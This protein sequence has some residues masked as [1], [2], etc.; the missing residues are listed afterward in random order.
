MMVIEFSFDLR[1][2][3][4]TRRQLLELTAETD[5]SSAISG[6][7]ASVSGF[8]GGTEN[9]LFRSGRIGSPRKSNHWPRFRGITTHSAPPPHAT[10]RTLLET[11]D[12]LP[13]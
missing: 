13:D 6:E 10:S 4:A 1:G 12:A 3:A 2:L 9:D 5:K 8:C 7:P 11:V